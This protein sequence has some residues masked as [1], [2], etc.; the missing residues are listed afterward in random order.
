MDA[1]ICIKKTDKEKKTFRGN[2]PI[3]GNIYYWPSG[4]YL[5][6]KWSGPQGS[7]LG[8]S[9]IGS[10]STRPTSLL[11]HFVALVL[12]TYYRYALITI[13]YLGMSRLGVGSRPLG[14]RLA[15]GPCIVYNLGHDLY[16]YITLWIHVRTGISGWIFLICIWRAA[17]AWSRLT[18]FVVP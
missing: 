9:A 13:F 2:L 17:F 16:W 12:A 10:L 14:L 1:S 15:A 6:I 18:C 11:T 8:K 3:W 4:Y 5:A 7:R